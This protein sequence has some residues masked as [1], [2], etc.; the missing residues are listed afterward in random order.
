MN[1]TDLANKLKAESDTANWDKVIEST[2]PEGITMEMVNKVQ[3]HENVVVTA[4]ARAWGEKA[5]SEMGGNEETRME[6]KFKFGENLLT[7]TTNRSRTHANPR[8]PSTPVVKYGYTT[9]SVRSNRGSDYDKVVKELSVL[10][11]SV[12]NK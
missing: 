9:V 7:V 12:F 3:N 5:I 4:L 2:L 6:G 10:G 11:E 1:Y 8:D